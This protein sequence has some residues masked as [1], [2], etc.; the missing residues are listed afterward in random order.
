MQ[1]S[2]HEALSIKYM[3]LLWGTLQCNF[4]R[5]IDMPWKGGINMSGQGRGLTCFGKGVHAFGGGGI[6]CRGGGG[7]TCLGGVA[8]EGIWTCFGGGGHLGINILLGWVGLTSA[9]QCKC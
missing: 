6:T 9:V 8:E 1:C 2:S 3:Q 7:A 4:H 5:S